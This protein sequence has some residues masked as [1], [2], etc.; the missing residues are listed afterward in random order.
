MPQYSYTAKDGPQKMVRD[1][2]EAKD[3]DAVVQALSQQGLVAIDIVPAVQGK[4]SPVKKTRGHKDKLSHI[5]RRGLKVS[6]Q[7]L[8]VFTR[9]MSDLVDAFVPL[10]RALQITMTQTS[11]PG[12]K[13]IIQEMHALVRDGAS[14]SQALSRYRPIF[15]NF[16]VHMIQTGEVGGQLNVV[17][18]R[19][20]DYL[21]KE[22]QTRRQVR[23]SLAY[24]L[25]ILGVGVLTVFVLM[26]FVIPRLAMMFDDLNQTL[27]LPTLILMYV[28]QIFEHY[29]G[30]IL[31]IVGGLVW[32][33][34]QWGMSDEGRVRVD[35]WALKVPVWGELIR[36]SETSNFARTLATL[37]DNG[38]VMSR[39][40]SAVWRTVDNTILR[41]EMQQVASQVTQG[42]SLKKALAHCVFFPSMAT[43]MI[44][45]GEE[46]GHLARALYKVADVYE[47]QSTQTVQTCV[48]LLGPVVLVL[49]VAVVGFVVI[50]ML[51]PIFQMNMG[52]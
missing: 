49:I 42:E 17:L 6:L 29:W 45:V 43:N 8:V 50:A 28:S 25:L 44:S 24:P 33:G 3:V 32:G 47:R 39:A 26:A 4:K 14:F 7:D 41:R 51:L 12:L 2:M 30:L 31:A 5:S 19:L 10:L 37:L 20:A 21:E 11:G 36:V 15:S 48:S 1:V 34:R 9:Q 40:L 16:Y 38:V 23:S 22:A 13:Q 35:W 18:G 52:V 27:P 46:T